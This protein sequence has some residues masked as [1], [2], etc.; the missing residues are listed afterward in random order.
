MTEPKTTKPHLSPSG[1]DLYCKCG[2][3]WRR[4]YV[5]KE[6]VPPAIVQLQGRG[7]H[8]GAAYNFKQKIE[9]HQDVPVGELV[10]A[11]VAG[12]ENETVGGYVLSDDEQSMGAKRVVAQAK[13]Q[14]AD[15]AKLHAKEV[16]PEYQPVLVERT[17]RLN[18]PNASHDLL[19]IIDLADDKR[20]VVDHKTAKQRTSQSEADASVQLT[21]YAA[22]HRVATG[23]LPTEM[24]LEVLV[25]N[26]TPVRQLVT[27]H[28]GQPDFQALS[29]RINTVLAGIHAGIFPPAT[30]GAWWCSSTYCGYHATCPFVRHQLVTI[31]M[32]KHNGQDSG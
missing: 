12:F 10:E 23:Y 27:T 13:D 22:A 2:E 9:S 24:R 26:K 5:E 21:Y 29:N 7:V 19:G 28:R 32:G 18:L 25:K 20:R 8:R 31:D 15:L 30:P 3:A 6:I 17:V 11:A 1:M 4:R 16:A 14:T